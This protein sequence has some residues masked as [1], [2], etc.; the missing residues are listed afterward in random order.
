MDII[1][2][3]CGVVKYYYKIIIK[4]TVSL[5]SRYLGYSL[6]SCSKRSKRSFYFTFPWPELFTGRDCRRCEEIRPARRKKNCDYNINM[7]MK[8]FPFELSIKIM[9]IADKKEIAKMSQ[10]FYE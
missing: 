3:E 10:F 4:S 7:K 9:L 8:I 1:N 2:V 6:R 5:L